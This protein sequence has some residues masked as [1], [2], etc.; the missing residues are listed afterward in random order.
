MKAW[1]AGCGHRFCKGCATRWLEQSK[2]CPMC[3]ATVLSDK[4]RIMR[5]ITQVNMQIMQHVFSCNM[6]VVHIS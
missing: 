3:R 2:A 6:E 1:P 4:Q 5:A